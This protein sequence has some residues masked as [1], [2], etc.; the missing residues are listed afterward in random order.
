MLAAFYVRQGSASEVLEVGEQPQ[1][2]PLP[3]EVLV[4]IAASGVNPSDVKSRQGAAGRPQPFP[5]IIPHSDGAGVISAVGEGVDATRIG[6]RVWLW[7]GQWRRP[8]G[9]AANYVALPSYQAVGLPD[10]LDFGVGACLGIPLMTAVHAVNLANVASKTVLVSGGAG[11]VAHYA[12][13]VAARRGARV[14]STVSGAKK[15]A[16]AMGAGALATIDYR[17][18]DIGERVKELTDGKGVEA[19]IDL[20]L[21]AN[22]PLLPSI[23][24]P[25]GTIV[26]YGMSSNDPVIPGRWLMQNN[27]TIKFLLVYA[28]SPPD[29]N[30]ALN[31]ISELMAGDGL[32]HRVA[33][34]FPLSEIVAAHEAVESGALFGNVIIE[35]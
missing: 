31:D 28:L 30:Q 35:P 12:I 6:E 11:A 34:S 3:G 7:N 10:S 27:A 4:R 24:Q 14:L 22:A 16:E 23:L 15:A 5:L 17:K 20:D 29:R 33:A 2:K 1:P 18:E 8:F 13:Q 25:G 9:T 32:I 21:T 26:V 19:V